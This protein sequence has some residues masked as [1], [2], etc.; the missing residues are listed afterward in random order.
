MGT[1]SLPSTGGNKRPHEATGGCRRPQ[2]AT[3]GHRMP[4]EVI[5]SSVRHYETSD[6][7]IWPDEAKR[8]H[9][10]PLGAR[11]AITKQKIRRFGQTRPREAT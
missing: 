4:Q 8:G 9:R 6:P 10:R 1:P 3:G 7:A 2:E 11:F 5:W